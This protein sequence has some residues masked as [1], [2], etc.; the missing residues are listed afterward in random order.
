MITAVKQIRF[1]GLIVLWLIALAIFATRAPAFFS[2]ANLH[3]NSAV[4]DFVGIG[5]A[6]PD[7]RDSLREAVASTFR[8]AELSVS[9]DCQSLF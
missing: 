8:S 4:L 5:N 9:V 7:F 3:L 6:W 1:G 2:L